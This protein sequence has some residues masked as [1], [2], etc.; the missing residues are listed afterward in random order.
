MHATP[1]NQVVVRRVLFDPHRGQ[2]D[3]GEESHEQK[4]GEQQNDIIREPEHSL[5]PLPTKKG[6]A[7][8]L[9]RA[10]GEHK[11]VQTAPFFLGELSQGG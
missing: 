5:T 6:L 4:E 1:S 9:T 11:T 3:T 2:A 10:C 7:F 8:N